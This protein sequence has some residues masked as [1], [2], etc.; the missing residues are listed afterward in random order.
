L[1]AALVR[2]R[3][4]RCARGNIAETFEFRAVDRNLKSPVVHQ[5]NVG[6]QYEVIKDL[7]FEA[8]YIGTRGRNLLQAVAFNQGYD[9]NDPNT[10]DHIYER[11]NQAYIRAGSPRGSLNQGATAR[12]RGRGIAFGFRQFGDRKSSGLESGAERLVINF[13]ARVPL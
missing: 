4:Y 5:F 8:R 10:P 9:L 7:L 11:F 12:D 2:Y 3:I 6:V 1:R 13:E